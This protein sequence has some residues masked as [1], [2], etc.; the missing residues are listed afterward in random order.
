MTKPKCATSLN[1]KRERKGRWPF[2]V[3]GVVERADKK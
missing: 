3:G 2:L 1:E